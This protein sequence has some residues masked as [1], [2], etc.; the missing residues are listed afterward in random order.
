MEKP[1]REASAIE[2]LAYGVCQIADERMERCIHC[3][4]EWYSIHYVDGVC[5]SCRQKGLPGRTTLARQHSFRHK[6]LFL[7]TLA[8]VSVVSYLAF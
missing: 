2:H 7:I 4:E 5:Q 6:A 3:N 1:E 8:V